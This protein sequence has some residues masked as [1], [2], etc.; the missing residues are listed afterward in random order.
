[1]NWYVYDCT[2]RIGHVCRVPSRF[3]GGVIAG[4]L[5]LVTG[6]FHD[7]WHTPEGI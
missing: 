4:F 6:R 3:T 7:T 5:T 2:A 1:M